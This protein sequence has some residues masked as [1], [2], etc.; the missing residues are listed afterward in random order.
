MSWLDLWSGQAAAVLPTAWMLHWGRSVGW[1]VVLACAG[2]RVLHGQ[3]APVRWVSALALAAWAC[4]PG[5]WSPTFWLGLAFQSPSVLGCLLCLYGLERSGNASAAQT[6]AYVLAY[7]G[8][9]SAA[10]S[11]S[12]FLTLFA[13]AGVALGYLL[14]L[15]T[16]ALL[17]LQIYAW[18]FGSVALLAALA[19]V[20]LPWVAGVR[21]ALVWAAPL[22]LLLF[23]LTRLPSGNMW[24]ALLDPITWV[25]LHL[26]LF[27]ARA[28]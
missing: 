5:E 7:S 24:D 23:A 28:R 19:V 9:R 20:L 13:W 14:L 1:A 8:G 2:A 22:S 6:G 17:P 26:V 10:V 4:V 18:G 27:K 15:D 11:Q 21:G 3:T 25:G 12:R 16:L